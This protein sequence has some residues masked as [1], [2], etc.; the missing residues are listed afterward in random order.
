MPALITHH[1]FGEEAATR[2]P[3]GAVQGQEGLIAFLVGS[4]GPDPLF[5]RFRTLGGEARS[6]HR[7]AREMHTRHV[8]RALVSLCEAAGARAGEDGAVARMFVLGLLAHYVLDSMTHPLICAQADA[9]C[10]AGRGL[11]GAEGDVHAVIESDLDTWVLW[12]ERHETVPDFDPTSVLATTERLERVAGELMA[13][14]SREV[15]GIGL[16]ETQYAGA[17][18]DYRLCY[19]VID[20]AGTARLR[21][22]GRLERLVR[23]H[24]RLQAMSHHAIRSDECPA[25]NLERREWHD[26]ST[27]SAST[28]SFAD[29]Y[30]DAIVAYPAFAS[31]LVAGDHERL[32]TLVAGRDYYGRVIPGR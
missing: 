18:A 25:A 21:L 16:G 32:A 13:Q 2:L 3:E 4:Q 26:P 20:P 6:C 7:L 10:A 17:L 9:L 11:E 31:A 14:V 5:A 15:F 29:L 30:H 24:S 1:L 8:T 27:G 22:L 12:Q 28:E 19:R 23:P